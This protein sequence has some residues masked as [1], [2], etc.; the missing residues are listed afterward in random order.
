MKTDKRVSK[1]ECPECGKSFKRVLDS[2]KV[3]VGVRRRRECVN[4]HRHTT[5]ERFVGDY[6]EIADATLSAQVVIDL[7]RDFASQLERKI[8][9]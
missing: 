3:G 1:L 5:H 9:R 2:R 4:G 6:K 8:E 7:L